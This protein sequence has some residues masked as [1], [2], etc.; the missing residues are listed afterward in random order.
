MASDT[1]SLV[2]GLGVVAATAFGALGAW[3]ARQKGRSTGE[4]AFLGFFLG[5]LG[6]LLE[7]LLPERAA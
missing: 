1:V 2:L 5:V 3:V 7:A 4:G 6:V